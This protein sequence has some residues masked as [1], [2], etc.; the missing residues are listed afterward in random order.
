[1]IPTFDYRR[2]TSLDDALAALGGGDAK[3]LA[4]GMSLLP[5]MKLGLAAPATLV[6]IGGLDDLRGARSTADGGFEIGALT[7]YAEALDA[8]NL[9]FAAE[10]IRGIGD[11]QVRNR[12]TVG[13][14]IAHADP[15]SD[16]PALALALDYEVVAR[17]AANRSSRSTASSRGPS[18][19]TSRPTRSSPHCAAVRYRPAPTVRTESWS[20]RL[21]AIRSSESAR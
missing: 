4:G 13:G 21:R 5:L 12:G 19:A 11:V 10:C 8:T 18:R 6:D 14:A 9:D 17:S 20:T 16:L 15:A 2:A 7:T 1:M 3:V